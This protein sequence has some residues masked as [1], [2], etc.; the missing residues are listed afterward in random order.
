MCIPNNG[1]EPGHLL[2][3]KE[4]FCLKTLKDTACYA[5]Q[6]TGV[7]HTGLFWEEMK[8]DTVLYA[9]RTTILIVQNLGK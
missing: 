1:A 8:Q 2:G 5:S 9:S 6:S 4:N 3:D 7:L